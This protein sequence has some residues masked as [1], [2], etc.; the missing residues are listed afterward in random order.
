[1]GVKPP[2][3]GNF[4]WI[5]PLYD[6]LAFVVFGHQLKRAQIAYLNRIPVG[7]SVLI[8]GG[9][10]GWL[11]EQVLRHCQ[12]GQV[13]YLETS[14][15]MVARA[16]QRI[17]KKMVPGSVDFRVGDEHRLRPGEQF[18]VI[19]TP[20]VLDLFSESTLLDQFIPSLLTTLNPTGLWSVTDFVNPPSAWQK[21]LLWFMIRFFRL[22]AGIEARKL[23]DWQQCLNK[24]GLRSMDRQSRVG[25]MVSAEVWCRGQ[26]P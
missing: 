18:D 20:F 17:L 11:L 13:V 26:N 4:N 2:P 10:T 12:P 22:T 7:A 15:Q 5:A 1:M 16:S 8:V 19:M 24:S 23:V 3:G 6:G 25:G 21:A 9:G 14:A